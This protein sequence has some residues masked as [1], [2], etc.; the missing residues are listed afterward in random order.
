MFASASSQF[1]LVGLQAVANTHNEWVA[2]IVHLPQEAG[3]MLA[4]V[5]GAGNAYAALAPLD[6]IIP[7]HDPLRVDDATLAACLP[8][9]TILRLPASLAGE[10]QVSKKCAQ[11]RQAG[12][13]IM[14][15]G[16]HADPVLA[17]Q[18]EAGSL[19]FDAAGA[20]PGLHQLLALP[21][22]H[23]AYNVDDVLCQASVAGLGVTWFAGNVALRHARAQND[24]D[25]GSTRRRLLALLGLLARD[26]DVQELEVPLKQDPVLAYHL[27]KLVNSAAFGFTA[28][29]TSFGQA[30]TMLGR[31]QLQRWLQLLLYARQQDDGKLN[32]LLPLAAVRAAQMEALCQL[33]GGA[34]DAQDQAFMTGVFSL[35]DILLGMPMPEIVGALNLAPAVSAALLDRSGELGTALALMENVVPTRADLQVAGVDSESWW[36]SLLQAYQWAIR[37]S[38]SV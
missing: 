31:R 20:L 18:A 23:M 29:I 3:G 21:G 25:D 30:I 13:R 4:S 14:F 34:R 27:L 19:S 38:R 17:A 15:D 12:Y 26:A 8:Q 33:R 6:L 32:A 16:A 2:V 5:L 36:R 9:R 28:P 7:L 35:L 24:A 10:P 22:P 37:L 1:P 11:W